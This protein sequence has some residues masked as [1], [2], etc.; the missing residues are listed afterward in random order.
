MEAEFIGKAALTRIN[1]KCLKH[2]QVGIQLDDQP[3]IGPDATF[4]PIQIKGE[5]VG[6]ITLTVYSPR[7]K[8]NIAV[9][10]VR[11]NRAALGNELQ[12]SLPNGKFAAGIVE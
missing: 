5:K 6:K 8:Q 2:K 9:G 7:L 4:W 10:F 11:I 1:A 12:V 3:L